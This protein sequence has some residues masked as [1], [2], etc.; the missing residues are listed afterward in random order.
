MG[1]CGKYPSV[2]INVAIGLSAAYTVTH[3]VAHK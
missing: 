1:L 3:E 2:S